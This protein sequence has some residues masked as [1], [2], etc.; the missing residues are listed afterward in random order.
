M[1]NG[2]GL[3][4]RWLKMLM[5]IRSARLYFLGNLTYFSCT[6]VSPTPVFHV[7]GRHK[8]CLSALELAWPRSDLLSPGLRRVALCRR[9]G[10]RLCGTGAERSF[11]SSSAGPLPRLW[12]G[13]R[14]GD[15]RDRHQL[16]LPYPGEGPRPPESHHELAS[17]P[18]GGPV[19]K[20]AFSFKT[21][22]GGSGAKARAARSPGD[23]SLRKYFLQ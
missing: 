1:R 10:H 14:A 9:G 12:L 11:G 7:L 5:K 3:P 17:T 4:E 8:L 6:T 15:P 19:A 22:Q 13:T 23:L 20:A 16:P 21:T 18:H 2:L